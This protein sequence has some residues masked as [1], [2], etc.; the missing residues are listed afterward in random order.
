MSK[1]GF[2]KCHGA[3][4]G[5]LMTG[6]PQVSIDL[7]VWLWAGR[8]L[9]EE[10]KKETTQAEGNRLWTSV[11]FIYTGKEHADSQGACRCRRLGANTNSFACL[12]NAPP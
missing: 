5:F 7:D 1:I 3:Q 9:K 8:G 11:G 6:R 4:F 10:K 12:A 2:S